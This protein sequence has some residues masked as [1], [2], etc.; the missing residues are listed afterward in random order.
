MSKRSP[1]F[2]D[3]P[4][5]AW[6]GKAVGPVLFSS[7]PPPDANRKRIAAMLPNRSGSP[8]GWK[9]AQRNTTPPRL[10]LPSVMRTGRSVCL[11]FIKRGHFCPVRAKITVATYRLMPSFCFYPIMAAAFCQDPFKNLFTGT[12]GGK[13]TQEQARRHFPAASGPAYRPSFPG[14]P[15]PLHLCPA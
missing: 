1:S 11:L 9:K 3:A 8:G 4:P 12:T 2:S 15:P 6:N 10:C 14:G 7:A 13:R 5:G